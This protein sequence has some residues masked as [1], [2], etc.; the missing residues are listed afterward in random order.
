M[1]DDRAQ[2]TRSV[3][4]TDAQAAA[5]AADVAADLI[6]GY[7]DLFYEF[8]TLTTASAHAVQAALHEIARRHRKA[9]EAEEGNGFMRLLWGEEENDE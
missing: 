3:I 1:T 6:D 5:L 2:P 8:P 4:L 9:S 7:G